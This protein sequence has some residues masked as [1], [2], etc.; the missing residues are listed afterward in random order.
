MRRNRRRNYAHL[1]DLWS[2]SSPN[3][4]GV[5]ADISYALATANVACYIFRHSRAESESL[6]GALDINAATIHFDPLT[7]LASNWIAIEKTLDYLG[8]RSPNYG[9]CF[10][11]QANP[12][13][14]SEIRRRDAGELKALCFEEPLLPAGVSVEVSV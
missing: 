10:S 7:V 6:T 14:R 9:K 4:G 11:V 8:N 13:V 2:Y 5:N 1:V 3:S 12:T